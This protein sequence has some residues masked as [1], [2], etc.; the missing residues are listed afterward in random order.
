MRL[1]FSLRALFLLTTVV[2]GVCLWFMLPSLTAK[3]FLAAIAGE[4]YKSADEFFLNDDDR[5]LA[6]WSDK[7]WAF[8]S[9]AELL[10]LTFG[11]LCRN[12]RQVRIGI[13]YFEFD[14]NFNCEMLISTT[15]FGL[16]KPVISR[17]E[18]LGVILDGR[19]QGIP[20]RRR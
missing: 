5:F 6:H 1:R 7:R 3:H 12:E 9:S 13:T 11:Q 17:N 19:G 14:Q 10:P 2:A 15:P 8:R 4:D 16:K 20:A 18:R